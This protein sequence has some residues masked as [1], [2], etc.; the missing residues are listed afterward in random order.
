MKDVALMLHGMEAKGRDTVLDNDLDL[1][2]QAHPDLRAVLEETQYLR[3][4]TARLMDDIWQKQNE[5][6]ALR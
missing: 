4:E 5:I 1:L 3:N 2:A 6:D